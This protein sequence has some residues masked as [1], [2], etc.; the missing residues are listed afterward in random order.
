MKRWKN[1]QISGFVVCCILLNYV[2]RQISSYFALPLWLDSIGT[3]LTAYELGPVCGAV[4]GV[5]NN[6]IE[7]FQNPVSYVYA[8]TSALIG[9]MVGIFAKRKFFES[10]FQTTSLSVLITVLAGTI[11]TILNVIFYD[12]LTGNVWGN[13]VVHFLLENGMPRFLCY[14]AGEFYLDFPD[15]LLTLWMLYF[16]LKI[17]RRRRKKR[18]DKIGISMV[19]MVAGLAAASPLSAKAAEY[20]SYVQTIYNRKNGLVCGEANAITSDNNGILWIGTYAGLYRYTGSEMRLMEEFDSVK[21]VNCLYVDEEGRL[22]IGT[23]D[24]GVA[25]CINERIAN[26]M[27]TAEGM[28]SDSVR[29]IV[30]SSEGEYYIGTSDC[31]QLVSI[32][33]GLSLT[34]QVEEVHYAKSMSADERG[35]VAAVTSAGELYLM[36]GGQIKEKLTCGE[37]QE[38][39]TCCVYDEK[40]ILYAGT[41]AGNIYLYEGNGEGLEERGIFFCEK[42]F[43]INELF[44]TEEKVL[45]VCGESGI[46]YL[47]ENGVFQR[48]HTG[49]FDNSIDSMT[50]D[51]QGNMWF[52]S[53]RL[54]MLRLCQSSFTDLYSVAGL[55]EQVVNTVESME[56]ILYVGTD[57]GLDMLEEGSLER[58]ENELT[59]AL[60]GVRIRCIRKDSRGHLWIC[61]Y[62]KGLWELWNGEKRIYNSEN[63]RT[64]D[65]IRSVLELSDGTTAV[66]G[67]NGICFLKDGEQ[68]G[69]IGE[70][71]GLENTRILSLL[72]CKDGT[73]LAGT[74]GDGIAVIRQGRVAEKLTREKGLTSGVVLRL[75]QDL[76]SDGIFVV[77][78]NGLCFLEGEKVRVLS[79]FPYSNN[80]DIWQ[81]EDGKLFVLGSA[82]IYVT[83]YEDI[84]Q[85]Q[86]SNATLLNT[87]D[88]LTG[89]LTANAWNYCDEQ[90]NLYLSCDSGVFL[91]NMEQEKKKERSYRMRIA[92][93]KTEE[94]TYVARAGEKLVLPRETG[95]VE[96]FPEVI[97]FSIDDPYVRYYLEGLDETKRTLRQSELTS[98]VYPAL[99]SGSYQFHLEVLDNTRTKVLEQSTFS[100]EKEKEIYDNGWFLAYMLIV[101]VMMVAWLTWFIVRTQ[102]QRVIGL[103]KKELELARKQLEM[104]N[105][106][107]LAIARTVDAKDEYTSHHSQRVSEY[108]VLIAKKLGMKDEECENLRKI[109]LLHD[110]GK[111]GI[112]D[113]VLNKPG[114]LDD[115]EYA[116]MKSHVVK[117]AEIL[118]DFTLIDKVWEGALYH[119]E[120]YDGKG[121]VHGLKGEE[122]PLNARIIG[123]A[124]AFDAMTSSRVYRKKLDFGIVLEEIQKGRGTQFDPKCV[125][126]LLELIEEGKIGV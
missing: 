126:A 22:W 3:V 27:G 75:V 52:V 123:I 102:I 122:I 72:E 107:I 29:S 86:G 61:T 17:V 28:P 53:S 121:Y 30:Q 10:F 11:S 115:E 89:A 36:E 20:Q 35:R 60:E 108:A 21:N 97:N 91:V 7:G 42:D 79:G 59:E 62:G 83:E 119:H 49:E 2:G 25:L 104:G 93:V 51:Y 103:Q 37:K 111:I 33:G 71:E 105:Q 5:A 55:P 112:A 92:S 90:G 87:K 32:N 76:R 109:A 38:Q 67:E 99:S 84:F 13:G 88:G 69:H 9:V 100:F 80:Y 39:F 114:R 74:D 113:S 63:S 14:T 48:L 77:L 116:I 34:K 19:I 82:G 8:L 124:D 120:R 4:V 106:T 43:S 81:A 85:T 47:D 58:I 98:I 78:S 101:L 41:S 1:W 117:G 12:G 23:N 56:E 44:F 70:E 96:I 6:I 54:G 15:K 95:R 31:V 118:K 26:V 18:I 45:F 73:L 64:G 110:I 50:E 125:D 57:R 65:R 68:T 46:G 24:N 94:E 40:G 66:A 16:L